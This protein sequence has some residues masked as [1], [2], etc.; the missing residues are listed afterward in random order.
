MRLQE[1]ICWTAAALAIVAA[2]ADACGYT[3]DRGNETDCSQCRDSE[4][5]DC[6]ANPSTDASPDI[7]AE[8]LHSVSMD[9]LHRLHAAMWRRVAVAKPYGYPG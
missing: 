7:P 6:C 5:A 4:G 3:C 8:G 1:S 9:Q 2:T